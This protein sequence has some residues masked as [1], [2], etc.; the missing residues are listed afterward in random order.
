MSTVAEIE[1]AI[2][3]LP[4]SEYVELLAWL[5][6]RRAAQVDARF[7]DAILS[8]KFDALAQCAEHAVEAGQTLPLDAFLREQN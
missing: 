6:K 4:T 3:S 7:E 5:D 2:E 8:G 1:Q